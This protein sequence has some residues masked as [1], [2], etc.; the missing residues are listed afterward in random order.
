MATYNKPT[1]NDD[2]ISPP[3]YNPELIQN[4]TPQPNVNVINTTTTQ[5]GQTNFAGPIAGTS[6]YPNPNT[7]NIAAVNVTQLGNGAA[8][9]QVRRAPADP[10]YPY[11][12][13]VSYGP[14]KRQVTCVFCN[15]KVTTSQDSKPGTGNWLGCL[16]CCLFGFFICAPFMLCVPGCKTIVHTCPNC[17]RMVGAGTK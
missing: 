11:S 3:P 10:L 1:L 5:Y 7:N 17:G 14:E 8:L 6:P 13:T 16:C 12:N 9:V 4:Q 2:D 15:A